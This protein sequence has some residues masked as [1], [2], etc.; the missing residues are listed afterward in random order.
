LERYAA[1]GRS[2]SQIAI[3]W[4]H[5]RLIGRLAKMASEIEAYLDAFEEV[6]RLLKRLS[7]VVDQ[8]NSVAEAI[9]DDLQDAAAMV[10]SDWPT[11]DQLRGLLS[12]I[13]TSKEQLIQKW[14]AVPERI[15]NA[16]PNKRPDAVSDDWDEEDT[17]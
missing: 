14:S 17:D 16:M 4:L 13:A 8:I 1:A 11:R 2:L 12:E 9:T 10:P 15:R 5:A 3:V 7:A 6:Q